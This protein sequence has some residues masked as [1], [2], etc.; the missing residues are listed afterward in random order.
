MKAE[1][2]H[3]LKS[4]CVFVRS[5]V[6]S[7]LACGILLEEGKLCHVTWGKVMY[8]NSSCSSR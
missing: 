5:E 7:Y 3:C 1:D 2:S 6:S 8:K 4:D